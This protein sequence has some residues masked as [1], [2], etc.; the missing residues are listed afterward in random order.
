MSWR[1][2]VL[3]ERAAFALLIPLTFRPLHRLLRWKRGNT[4]S[5][6]PALLQDM[7]HPVQSEGWVPVNQ[8]REALRSEIALIRNL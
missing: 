3:Y 8:L 7:H 5:F 6:D 1:H 4:A 2:E